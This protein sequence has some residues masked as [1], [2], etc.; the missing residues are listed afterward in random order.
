MRL[1]QFPLSLKWFI[2]LSFLGLGLVLVAGYSLL[3][4]QYFIGGMDNMLANHMQLAAEAYER[5]TDKSAHR[6]FEEFNGYGM[7]WE[8]SHLP[9]EYAKAFP[10]PPEIP[11]Q[12]YKYTGSTIGPPEKLL[13]LFPFQNQQSTLY[14]T[15]RISPQTVSALL[16][17]NAQQSFDQLLLISLVCAVALVAIL[18]LVIR[19][20]FHPVSALREWTRSLTSDNLSQAAPDFAYP[21]LNELAELIRNSLQTVQSALEREH[22]FLRHTSH[23]LRTPISTIR[24]NIELLQKLQAS[25][26]QLPAAL[27]QSLDRID[28]SSLTMQHLTETLLWLSKDEQE[29]LPTRDV[30]LDR[31]VHTLV[32]DLRYLLR[33]K[34]VSVRLETQ[35]TK[36][37]A[38]QTAAVIVISNLIRNAFQH[39]WEGE[40]IIRQQGHQI[41]ITNHNHSAIEYEDDLGFGLG[42]QLTRRLCD[43][44][45]WD[46]RNDQTPAGHYACLTLGTV[47][48]PALA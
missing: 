11:N 15:F 12:L 31:L 32:Q 25:E 20:I 10:T 1:R 43:R 35:P 41:E 24:N 42:L 4:A 23:E 36:V 45:G 44:L 2:A 18:V 3:S 26:N 19:R 28:R 39:T 13:F 38:A 17:Q 48:R 27:Q 6:Q 37:H 34:A 40:V 46:Y 33:D 14:V 5:Q 8:W 16:R 21:E 7:T 22:Q 9:A 29:A 47:G 30:E